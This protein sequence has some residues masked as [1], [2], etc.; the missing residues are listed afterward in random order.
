MMIQKIISGGQTGADIAAIDAAIASGIN[1]G[2]W[3]PKGRKTEDGP[4]DT[5]YKNFLEH[6]SGSY[7][8]RTE[9][10]VK[11]S[12]ATLIFTRGKLK[13]GSKL[14]A[15]FAE[16]W[17]KPYL[18]IDLNLADIEKVVF[19]IKTWITEKKVDV[20][21][22]A[23]TRA[24]KDVDIYNDVFLILKNVLNKKTIHPID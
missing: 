11:D 22:V 24:S 14:T 19:C 4:L 23:G 16:S 9:R 18:H 15:D 7:P 20:L 1:Y 21:N 10:N 5:R 6:P 3:L 2:G 13:G 17:G 8:K 12:D